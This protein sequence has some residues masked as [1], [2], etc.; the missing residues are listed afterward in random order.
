MKISILDK[1]KKKKFIEGLSELGLS[2]I[3]ELLVRSGTE[4]IRA[5]SGSFSNEEIMEIWRMLP[6]EG[7]G[8]YV[9][10]ELID[11]HGRREIRLSIDGLHNWKNQ[12]TKNIVE[13]D[14]EM[15]EKWFKGKNLEFEK[16]IGFTGF[17]AVKSKESKDFIGTGKL[18][19]DGK[20]LF[21]YLPKERRRKEAVIN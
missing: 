2:K 1:A 21:S 9:G 6:I 20:T 7:V 18:S 17:V 19:D 16:P 15:E 4:R 8:L 14:E 12:I 5:Y 10:K 11:R 3:P 13:L